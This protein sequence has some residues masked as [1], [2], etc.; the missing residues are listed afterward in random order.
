MGGGGG[1]GQHAKAPRRR[2]ISE[3]PTSDSDAVLSPSEPPVKRTRAADGDSVTVT[4]S[5][6]DIRQLLD[7]PLGQTSEQNSANDQ[8]VKMFWG[9][10][11]RPQKCLLLHFSFSP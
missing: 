3:H 11:P 6:E 9:R 4:A 8:I 10:I 1:G 7:D 2:H 5:D